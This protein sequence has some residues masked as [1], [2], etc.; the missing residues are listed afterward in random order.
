MSRLLCLRLLC[1]RL[2]CLRVSRVESRSVPP[3]RGRVWSRRVLPFRMLQILATPLSPRSYRAPARR[4]ALFT[5]GKICNNAEMQKLE[6][7]PPCSGQ[8]R[9]FTTTSLTQ[10][11]SLTPV[12]ARIR[13]RNTNRRH[14]LSDAGRGWNYRFL[15]RGTAC[16][17]T[18][19]AA[20][21]R[22]RRGA[23]AYRP[24]CA[25]PASRREP[26]ACPCRRAPRR[27]S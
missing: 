26:R 11:L 13:W 24:S 10:D 16:R 5:S 18:S 2:L 23:R 21:S 20:T 7:S 15:S 25:G 3:R 9:P 6:A 4:R 22:P 1:L 19:G 12:F 8:P 14:P 17:D 27:A